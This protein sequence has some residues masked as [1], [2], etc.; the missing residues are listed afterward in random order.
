ML[1]INQLAWVANVLVSTVSGGAVGGHRPA[2]AQGTSPPLYEGD[3]ITS[4]V[5]RGH[6]LS[7]AT[8]GLEATA[9]SLW[10][11]QSKGAG[12]VAGGIGHIA[13]EGHASLDFQGTF[14][15]FF[16]FLEPLCNTWEPFPL[17]RCFWRCTGFR[18][19]C[20]M[21]YGS[22]WV[23]ALLLGSCWNPLTPPPTADAAV[24]SP[25]LGFPHTASTSN[26][27]NTGNT[28]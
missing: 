9:S 16:Q 12:R 11:S 21:V 5:W 15:Y 1:S 25:A 4:L 19:L 27:V 26:G 3:I 2:G 13:G 18:N 28:A 23:L 14:N 8:M 17:L 10:A 6:H 24:H 7:S 20:S 22:I